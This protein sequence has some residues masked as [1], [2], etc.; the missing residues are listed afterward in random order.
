MPA[1]ILL[2]RPIDPT[3]SEPY[4]PTSLTSLALEKY[5]PH[6]SKSLLPPHN[7][8]KLSL[9][10]SANASWRQN[11][12]TGPK[13]H[14]SPLP[15]SF[16]KIDPPL[17]KFLTPLKNG[18]TPLI[19]KIWHP[20]LAVDTLSALRKSLSENGSPT[21]KELLVQLDDSTLPSS[22]NPTLTDSKMKHSQP[23]PPFSTTSTH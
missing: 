10:S 21:L 9:P 15:D 12:P 3:S 5:T 7:N 14:Y 4:D 1:Q 8:R 19:S 22:H 23:W 13:N 6:F 16:A 2:T 18:W 20:P 17:S 11:F